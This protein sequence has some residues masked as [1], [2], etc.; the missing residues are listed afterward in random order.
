MSQPFFLGNFQ[1]V[2]TWVFLKHFELCQSLKES[3]G[4]Q[5]SNE[6]KNLGLRIIPYDP[7]MILRGRSGKVPKSEATFETLIS[8]VFC[9]L[10]EVCKSL[11]ESSGSQLSNEYKNLGLRI[12]PYDPTMIL[13]GRS[14]KVPKSEATFETLI[15]QVFCKLFEVCKSLKYSSGN[16]LS[17]YDTQEPHQDTPVLHNSI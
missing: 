16:W 14:G 2:I 4:S 17:D 12:I 1:T 7:T 6:Y 3:S 13:R 9:K 5:L 10:F 15:S 8:R 11:K